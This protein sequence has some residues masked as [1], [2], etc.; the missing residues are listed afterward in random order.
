[1]GNS[2]VY[3][4]KPWTQVQAPGCQQQRHSKADAGKYD[5]GFGRFDAGRAGAYM[6]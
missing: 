6:R 2:S 3:S 4:N 1:M 5:N